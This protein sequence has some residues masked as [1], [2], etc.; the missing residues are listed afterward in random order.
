MPA[1]NGVWSVN[2]L[3]LAQLITGES[4]PGHSWSDAQA[5][6]EKA[7]QVKQELIFEADGADPPRLQLFQ[8]LANA[9]R[10]P[11]RLA[12]IE[13]LPLVREAIARYGQDTIERIVPY[14]LPVADAIFTIPGVAKAQNAAVVGA[15]RKIESYVIGDVSFLDPVQG[16][17]NDCYLISAMIALAWS[18]PAEWTQ[19]VRST[20]VGT[21]AST[22][23]R[24]E[25]FGG[26]EALEPAFVVAPWLPTDVHHRLAYARST[27]GSEAWAP[28]FEKAFVMRECGRLT[29]DPEP[30]DY[31]Y[32]SD[33]RL[34]PHTAC[35]ALAGGASR[36][37]GSEI[38]G[39]NAPS[40]TVR[41]R[42][43]ARRVTT[44][45]TM[46]WTWEDV[47][48]MRGLGWKS[49]GLAHNHA[50]AV[51]GLMSWQGV[52]HV[53]LR[54][55]LGASPHCPGGHASGKWRPGPGPSGVPEVELAECGVFAL[56]ADWFDTCFAAVGWVER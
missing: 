3:A 44:E 51:L 11:R 42:C 38:L 8:D 21:G 32:I 53:V 50:Y 22:V 4:I 27:D 6:L 36:S 12:E 54:N 5:V 25:F 15:Y 43:D 17:V 19:R 28:M 40:A 26:P 37:I 13:E 34:K 24:Y 18:R 2:P 10:D 16:N 41:Q 55:P 9:V 46:A 29:K 7:F 45:P 1:T 30:S 35:R 20:V 23:Y 48:L 31:Q 33:H 52:D 49:T 14:L 47:Q 56:R 39:G